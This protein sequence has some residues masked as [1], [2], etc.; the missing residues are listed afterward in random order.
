MVV[1]QESCGLFDKAL[2]IA[3]LPEHSME[4]AK[5]KVRTT[6]LEDS[7]RLLA[8]EYQRHLMYC[9]PHGQILDSME[10]VR[11]TEEIR[12]REKA[13]EAYQESGLRQL[14]AM[15]EASMVRLNGILL[16][17]LKAYSETNGLSVMVERDALII[18]SPCA[19]HT[20][21]LL[22]FLRRR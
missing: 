3:A 13:I 10:V 8:S 22:E 6:Q 11:I 17:H 1:A 15:E 20:N 12:F 2:C 16:V 18:G 14:A 9:T 19:D 5:L 21:D 4:A 7:L